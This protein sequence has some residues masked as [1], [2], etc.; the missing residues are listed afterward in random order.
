MINKNSSN[1]AAGLIR[2]QPQSFRGVNSRG[3]VLTVLTELTSVFSSWRYQV[4]GSELPARERV[5][6]GTRRRR[7][8]PSDVSRVAFVG[9][10]F[11]LLAKKA[12]GGIAKYGG[13]LRGI[14]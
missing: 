14:R 3:R 12:I 5:C 10:L 2:R 13:F 6:E 9:V 4:G 1:G 8:A 7:A 11:V